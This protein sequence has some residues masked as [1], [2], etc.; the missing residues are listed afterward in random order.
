MLFAFVM[1]FE[2]HWM[3]LWTYGTGT[4]SLGNIMCI[5]ILIFSVQLYGLWTYH[6]IIMAIQI[7]I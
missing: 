7:V 4:P 5:P 3:K 2:K 6:I 1:N